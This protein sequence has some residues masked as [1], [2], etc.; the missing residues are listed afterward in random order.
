MTCLLL[1]TLQTLVQLIGII[2]MLY[3]KHR[4]DFSASEFVDILIVLI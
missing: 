1:K 2:F 3:F 4:L